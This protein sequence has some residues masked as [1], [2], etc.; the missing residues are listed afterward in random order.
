LINVEAFRGAIRKGNRKL[1]TLALRPGKTE[2][3]D[4]AKHPGKHRRGRQRHKKRCPTFRM[5]TLSE[6]KPHALLAI[7]CRGPAALRRRHR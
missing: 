2:L 1:V 6:A 7:L 4:L 5:P 3:F